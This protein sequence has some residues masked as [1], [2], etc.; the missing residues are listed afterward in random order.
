MSR[1]YEQASPA[2]AATPAFKQ[3]PTDGSPG[4][5]VGA[6]RGQERSDWGAQ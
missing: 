6:P 3:R 2:S 4:R 5:K 1:Q